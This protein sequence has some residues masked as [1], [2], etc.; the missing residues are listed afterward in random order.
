M[1]QAVLSALVL[2]PREV[3][4]VL[5]AEGVGRGHFHVPTNG[6]IFDA[7]CGLLDA[8][9]PLDFLTIATHLRNENRLD[10]IGG[11]GVVSGLFTYLATATNFGFYLENVL[12][13]HALREVIRVGAEFARRAYE[14]G[15]EA[16]GLIG[17][18]HAAVT[19]LASKKASRLSLKDAL[20][21]ILAE[22]AN[23]MDDTGALD[24][25][26][27][28]IHGRLTLYRGDLL[29]ISAPTSCGKSALADQ[30]AI[31]VALAG[32]RSAIYTLEM[33]Q[34][35]TLKRAIA[36]L[37]G[38]NTD[39]IRRI[40]ANAKFSG[41]QP[42]D[43]VM[44][45]VADFKGAVVKI[46]KL[47]LHIRDDLFRIESILAD[48]RAEYGRKPIDFIVI[49][50]LQLIQASGKF[51]RKQLQIAAITQGLKALAK[52][53]NCVICLPSQVNKDGGTREAQDA[54]NDASA[55][56]KIHPKENEEGD[57]EPGRISVWKQREGARHIDLPLVFNP[58]ITR[59]DYAAETPK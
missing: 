48:I 9:K 34:R 2:S 18:F 43:F 46:S 12:E 24:L 16:T 26:T 10:A 6:E 40:V 20:N 29:V 36:R 32:N 33:L 21:E 5:A 42:S 30:F 19:A 25:N 3:R 8:G 15:E 44:T 50:Y 7:L 49:D 51:E 22:V 57:I 38:E 13:K 23:G 37:S 53:L 4:A 58:S 54:E 35:Q 17:E 28:G 14:H 55:L 1:E 56:I 52:E 11:A 27:E 39:F 59:F 47:A 41:G 31:N 45:K